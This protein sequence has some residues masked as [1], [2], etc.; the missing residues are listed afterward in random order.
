MSRASRNALTPR[1][2]LKSWPEFFAQIITGDK[3]HEVRRT[4]RAFEVGDHLVLA[5]YD[6]ESD[7]YSGRRCLVRVTYITSAASPCPFATEA[8][9]PGF[10]LLSISCEVPDLRGGEFADCAQGVDCEY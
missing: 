1:Y 3:R 10:V 8:L 7:A 6:P 5:E 2:E 9:S 4:D